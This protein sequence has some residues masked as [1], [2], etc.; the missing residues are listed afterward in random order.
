MNLKSLI[1]YF[2]LPRKF[3]RKS[4]VVRIPR[5][6][7]KIICYNDDNKNNRGAFLQVSNW[8]FKFPKRLQPQGVE[9][10]FRKAAFF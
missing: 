8:V 4:N 5:V 1:S 2:D 9:I 10:Y 7:G 6:A 3:E